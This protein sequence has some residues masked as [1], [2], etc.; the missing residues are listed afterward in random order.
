[1]RTHL[2]IFMF[3]FCNILSAIDH[4]SYIHVKNHGARETALFIFHAKKGLVQMN[5][6]NS[7]K[8]KLILLDVNNSVTFF[9]ERP[10]RQAGTLSIDKFLD[11]WKKG[12]NNFQ[13]KS[14]FCRV[15]ILFSRTEFRKR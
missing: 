12:N 13:S 11:S 4:R 14:A 8:G 1:M 9:A 7:K 6:E 5:E 10:N 2:I 15:N 3:V